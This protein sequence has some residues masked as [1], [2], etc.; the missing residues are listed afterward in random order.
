MM[1]FSAVGLKARVLFCAAG[2]AVLSGGTALAGPFGLFGG[3]TSQQAEVVPVQAG[4][5]VFR[6]GQL[7]EEIRRLNGRIEELSFQI[8]QMQERMR[9]NQEDAEFRFQALEGGAPAGG[10][11]ST[12]PSG[13]TNDAAT[14]QQQGSLTPPSQDTTGSTAAAPGSTVTTG[15][16]TGNTGGA[17]PTPGSLGTIT[18]DGQGNLS[19][20][21][22]QDTVG[23]NGSGAATASLSTDNP[24]ALYAEAYNLV[25]AG[26]YAEAEAAFQDYV[27]IYPDG[28]RAADASF[29]LGESQFSQGNFND[30]A[31]TFLNAHQNHQ[32]SEKAPE[33]LLKLGMSLAALENRETACATYREVLS[34][35]PDVS[36]A[37]RDKVLRE[38][39]SAGC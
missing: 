32:G 23:A 17:A 2:L 21:L 38:Q 9:Q 4:D 33:M 26:D 39:E 36:S 6:I 11:G 10:S 3:E 16:G 8:I 15:T 37:V 25:L 22:N 13:D 31:R 19:A 1:A 30:A 34:R 29:W 35:Y 24:E 12:P 14:T 20:T 18:F 27:D 28:E 7:E 5:S